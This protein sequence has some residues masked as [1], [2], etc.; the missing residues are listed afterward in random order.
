MAD[1]W[2]SLEQ[3][4]VGFVQS[5]VD[6]CVLYHG[7]TMY[8]LYTNDSILA[9]PDEKEI[10]QII[11]DMQKAKLNITIEEDLQDF[12]GV[13]IDRKE[14]GIIHLTQPHLINQI[15]KDLRLDGDTVTKKTVPASSSKLLLRHS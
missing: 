5:K 4:Q 11:K 9:G 6:E 7:K 3:V 13:N 8:I 10:N 12:L 1:D 14:D 15:L 2:S